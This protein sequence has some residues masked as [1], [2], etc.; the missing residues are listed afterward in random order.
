M[1]TYLQFALSFW[2]TSII[3]NTVFIIIKY[4][5]SLSENFIGTIADD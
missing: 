5:L 1:I 4:I 3:K 2:Q